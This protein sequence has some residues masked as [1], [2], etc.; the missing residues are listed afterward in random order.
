[1]KLRFGTVVWGKKFTDRFLT[2]CLPGQLSP[3][4][5]P[6]VA[7]RADCRYR[8]YTTSAD[9]DTIRRSVSHDALASIMPVE[10]AEISGLALVGRYSAMTQCHSHFLKSYRSEDVAFVTTNPDWVWSNGAMARLLQLAEAGKRLVALTG[11]RVVAESFLPEY[12][13]QLDRAP[14]NVLTARELVRLALRHLHPITQS[15]LWETT[16]RRSCGGELWWMVRDEGLLTRQFHLHP[17]LVRPADRQIVL[18]KTIDADYIT[19]MV[20][21]WDDV[22]IV[23]DSD[24]LCILDFTSIAEP[25]DAAPDGNTIDDVVMWA[26]DSTLAPHREFVLRPIRFHWT[27]CSPAWREVEQ[28]S[29]AVVATILDRLALIPTEP[30]RLSRT[31]Y[32]RPGFWRAKVLRFGLRQLAFA[33]SSRLLQRVGGALGRNAIAITLTTGRR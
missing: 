13:Q 21:T 2:A 9:A 22:H 19:A 12:L 30:A 14:G 33:A 25:V 3:Q 15:R 4:N 20:T 8:I 27:D 24:D 31:R 7:T 5:L 32:L 17:I 18:K 29:D 10:I 16:G 26:R 6:F 1:M 23:Q 11:P 28:R